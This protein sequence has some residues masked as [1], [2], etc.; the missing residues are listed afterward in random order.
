MEESIRTEEKA[1][2]IILA[3]HGEKGYN[4]IQKAEAFAFLH[5]LYGSVNE[6]SRITGIDNTSVNRYLR[7]TELPEEVK[8]L[9]STGKIR[10]YHLASELNRITDI[11]RLIKTAK[12][13]V[14]VPREI[15]R[16]IIRYVLKHPERS[17]VNC[18]KTVLEAYENEI[19]LHIYI[20]DLEN[21]FN[22]KAVELMNDFEVPRLKK[23]LKDTFRLENELFIWL[24]NGT[25]MVVMERGQI[26]SIKKLLKTSKKIGR[27]IEEVVRS[28]IKDKV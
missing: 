4:L 15:G 3:T 10:S 13:V 2:A 14:G 17:I 23:A 16:E 22:E 26:T 6:V 12:S 18:V 7:I 5:R 28:V 25:I 20:L 24:E 8:H 19:D 27:I 11:E 21:L 9:V 1:L